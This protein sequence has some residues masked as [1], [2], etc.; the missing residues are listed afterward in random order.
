MGN[1]EVVSGCDYVCHVCAQY[2][3]F[4]ANVFYIP[5]IILIGVT[6]SCMDLL[7]HQCQNLMT[8]M[9]YFTLVITPTF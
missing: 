7:S 6:F 8:F 3:K 2:I 4:K 9:Y 1:N 5:L